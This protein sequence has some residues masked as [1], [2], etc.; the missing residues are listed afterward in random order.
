MSLTSHIVKV[1]E[2]I[3]R[4]AIVKHL[5]D[6][7][8]L[9]E[10]QHAYIRGRSTLSQLLNH[11]EE[12]I[13][14]WEEDK[15]TDTIYLD[16]AKAFDKVDHDILCHKLRAL[17]IT[18][19]V[20]VWIKEFLSGRYQQVSANG[21]LSDSSKVI[22][23]IPQ[24]TVLGPILFII[25][26]S[27]LGKDLLFSVASKYADDTK[28]TTKIGN[29]DDSKC[30]QKE[31]DE[32]V[33]PWAP[34]NNMCLNGDKFEHHR[35]GNNLNIEKHSY[36]DPN[37]E[38]I[39]EKEYIKDLGVYISSDLTWT[40]Q[41]NEVV[42]KT[43]SMAGWALRTF[44][45][46]MEQPMITVWNSL[47]RPC[48]DY[49]SPVWSPRPSNLQE[50]DLLEQ[51][52]RSFTRQIEGMEGLDYAERL[53][54]LHMYSVQRRNERF[55]IIYMYKIK[56][57]LVPNISNKYRLTF[58][59]NSRRGCICD[60]PAFPLGGRARKARDNSFAWTACNLWNSLPKCIRNI[61]GE[62]VMYFKRKLDEALAFYP[63][64][65]RCSESG[66]T[67]DRNGRKSNSLC[68][69]YNYRGVEFKH[70]I[71]NMNIV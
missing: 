6:N 13:R 61:T 67:Y 48:L 15:A 22:S 60:I 33:Y 28:N 50:I 4:T 59:M 54:E 71:E 7:D 27:D 49:C 8:L 55:K 3:V 30:F 18:G 63:D 42:S 31:L 9:P 38:V 23:G 62:D 43:T 41:I 39:N 40:R 36:L 69:H 17:G 12:A 65:P 51:T 57:N 37:G 68:D 47:V 1:F 2:R 56:E 44:R 26:I 11:V 70:V 64:V 10:D 24:G 46:R 14:N 25:M 58:R 19:K 32:K 53:R 52:Q 16:F 45:T 35:I 5:E 29:T 66:H 21:L 34:K 20:G